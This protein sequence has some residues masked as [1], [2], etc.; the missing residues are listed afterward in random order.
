MID[1]LVNVLMHDSTSAAYDHVENAYD[2]RG[3]VA[4]RADFSTAGGEVLAVVEA[5]SAQRPDNVLAG[6]TPA[7]AD[8]AAAASPA[9]TGL[10]GFVDAWSAAASD[11]E[12]Q[13]AQDDTADQLYWEPALEK[14]TVNGERPAVGVTEALVTGGW[15]PVPIKR[16]RPTSPVFNAT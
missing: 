16:M 8:L 7:L 6:F 4:G 10:D 12:F 1:K 3:Y 2:G 5:Y 11:P 9:L 15:S 13:R 14:A